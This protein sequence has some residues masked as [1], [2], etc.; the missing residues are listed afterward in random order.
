MGALILSQV[1]SPKGILIGLA[2]I[3]FGYLLWTGVHFEENYVALQKANVT[4]Q[5]NLDATNSALAQEKKNE[6]A[7][8]S[9]AQTTLDSVRVQTF[10]QQQQTKIVNDDF[11]AIQA[12]RTPANETSACIKSP[13]VATILSRMRN[14]AAAPSLNS[15]SP[16]HAGSTKR[17]NHTHNHTSNSS[18]QLK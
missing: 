11:S 8:A 10:Q 16:S 6:K 18:S 2:T 12:I 15:P 17:A 1:L 9:I 14:R 7:Q 5:N 4:L 3:I 13:Y